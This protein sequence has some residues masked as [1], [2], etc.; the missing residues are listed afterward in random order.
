MA[1]AV[2]YAI[3]PSDDFLLLLMNAILETIAM[4]QL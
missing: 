2:V 3:L 4:Q 1:L